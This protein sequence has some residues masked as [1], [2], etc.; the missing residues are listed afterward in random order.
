M[1]GAVA[2][3]RGLAGLT[4]AWAEVLGQE[5]LVSVLVRCAALSLG[6]HSDLGGLTSQPVS[7]Q[8]RGCRR[9]QA[10]PNSCHEVA[11]R[12]RPGIGA[13]LAQHSGLGGLLLLGALHQ[14]GQGEGRGCAGGAVGARGEWTSLEKLES[15]MGAA[16]EPSAAMG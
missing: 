8:E 9:S 13:V 11:H 3:T 6:G 12:A 4:P 10:N 7:A 16:A 14:P 15:P 2:V 5:V 1:C